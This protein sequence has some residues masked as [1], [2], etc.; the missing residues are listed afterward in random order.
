MKDFA[1]KMMR[2]QIQI[3][4]KRGR[5]W[6]YT[7]PITLCSAKAI[8]LTL[9]SVSAVK[10]YFLK[11]GLKIE[12]DGTVDHLKPIVGFK[13]I[14]NVQQLIVKLKSLTKIPHMNN[15]PSLSYK[16]GQILLR[17]PPKSALVSNSSR[18]FEVLGL[19]EHAAEEREENDETGVSAKKPRISEKILKIENDSDKEK[20]IV[21]E[22]P[23]DDI[24]EVPEPVK[25][26]SSC[27]L[28]REVTTKTSS[29]TA[30][31]GLFHIWKL[32]DSAITDAQKA[33]GAKKLFDIEYIFPFDNDGQPQIKVKWNA[34]S[35]RSSEVQAEV[36]VEG[37]A[38]SLLSVPSSWKFPSGRN[39]EII[40]SQ[41]MYKVIAEPASDQLEKLRPLTFEVDGIRLAL[42]SPNNSIAHIDQA[43]HVYFLN[44]IISDHRNESFY[45]TIR[46]YKGHPIQLEHCIL[47]LNF[48]SDYLELEPYYY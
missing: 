46:D 30:D 2:S 38:L 5:Q 3:E 15:S 8:G 14:K 20:I 16:N 39:V 31:A 10:T 11:F 17:L 12:W 22:P 41:K 42:E 43:G 25:F 47:T 28:S 40:P 35:S 19:S 37:S 27:F 44:R 7:M 21:A 9:K 36:S 48:A 45:L 18:L 34:S 4:E 13:M 1:D 26:G 24:G 6:D 29:F 33:C 23:K 32:I